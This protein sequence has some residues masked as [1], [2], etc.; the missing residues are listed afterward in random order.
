MQNTLDYLLY[1]LD[2]SKKLLYSKWSSAIEVSQ[3]KEG[4]LHLIQVINANETTL[5]IHESKRMHNL[6]IED[7]KWLT[8]VLALMVSQSSLK[9]IAIVRPEN[10]TTPTYC[11]TLR[12]KA[13]RIYGKNIHL[14]F[15]D[16]VE[17]AK[18][19]ILPNLQHY[20]LP[21]LYITA[22]VG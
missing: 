22:K 12:E 21:N 20:K 6:A 13:Y 18:A 16:S 3:Y 15:F 10:A 14:E 1:G 9:Y 8:Q 11:Y 4:L 2:V 19:W 5:W 17:E 7:Q